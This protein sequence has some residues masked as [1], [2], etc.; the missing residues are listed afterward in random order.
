ME[1]SNLGRKLTLSGQH[2]LLH[3]AGVSWE[4]D[5]AERWTVVG[6]VLSDVS[7]DGGLRAVEQAVQE[8]PDV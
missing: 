2:L 8:R 4:L 6:G 3:P 7:N 5:R 1:E